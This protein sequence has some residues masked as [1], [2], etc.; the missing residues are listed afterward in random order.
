MHAHNYRC[1]ELHTQLRSSGRS[2]VV[3]VIYA[4]C[5][6][7]ASV[8]SYTVMRLLLDCI[9][10]SSILVYSSA[11]IRPDH[12][13][14]MKHGVSLHIVV[15]S[16]NARHYSRLKC[17]TATEHTAHYFATALL[18]CHRGRRCHSS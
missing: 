11:T 14:D 10:S 13:V 4:H 12:T 6:C 5:R 16:R 17:T 2:V 1:N 15:V 18:I 9:V 8:H 7:I 3:N